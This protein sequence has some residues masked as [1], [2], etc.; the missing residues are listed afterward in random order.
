MSGRVRGRRR[1]MGRAVDDSGAAREGG[2][3]VL[4]RIERLLEGA[5]EGTTRGLFRVRI[6]PVELAKAAARAMEEQQVI[7]PDGPEV[8][9]HYRIR[10]HPEDF[11]QFAPYRASLVAKIERY[12]DQYARDRALRPVAPWRI[13]LVEDPGARKRRVAVDALMEDVDDPA[14]GPGL[15]DLPLE[16]TVAMPSAAPP[17]AAPRGGGRGQIEASIVL[18]D[19]RLLPLDKDL[20]S[21]GRA[22]DNDVVIADSRVSR[23]HVQLV[24]DARGLV[25]RDLGSTNGTSVAGRK[26]AE[27]RLA[28]GDR[29]SL[30]GYVVAVR[31]TEPRR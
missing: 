5:V 17:T 2:G 20:T 8:A 7:G 21:V 3:D 31:L 12:V 28:D 30:G 1:Q 4:G 18:E 29:V 22:L 19:G 6:Q 11:A 9:N 14:G 13:E 16:G 24:R 26:V 23:Y 10:L 25:L 27:L 15:S